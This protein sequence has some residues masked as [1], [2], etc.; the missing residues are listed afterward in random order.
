M[1]SFDTVCAM[2]DDVR[3]HNRKHKRKGFYA[4]DATPQMAVAHLMEEVAEFAADVAN[5]NDPTTELADVL[6]VLLHAIRV[7][8][9]HDDI[10]I[11][12]AMGKLQE[13]FYDSE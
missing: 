4:L 3:Q 5:G 12:T 11:S 6:A 8:G 2:I 10:I 7:C 9:S 1:S 13:V